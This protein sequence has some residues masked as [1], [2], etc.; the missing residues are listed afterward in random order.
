MIGIDVSA[1]QGNVDF[2]KVK[3][4]GYDFVIIRG[5][6][7]KSNVD[8]WFDRNIRKALANGLKVG[9]YWFIYAKDIDHVKHNARMCNAILN[10]YRDKLEMGVWAD[11]EYDSD[12]Y[13]PKLTK[14]E[15]TLFVKAFIEE[16]IKMGYDCGLY[17]NPDYINNK[18]NYKVENKPSLWKYPLWLAYYDVSEAKAKEYKPLIWQKTSK[19]KVNGVNGNV[20]IDVYFGTMNVEQPKPIANNDKYAVV[21][22]KKDNLNIRQGNGTKYDIISSFKKGTEVKIIKK[23]G[24]WWFVEGKDYKGNMVQGYCSKTY[25]KEI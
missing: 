11:W 20:D 17:A 25:L 21:E 23:V 5:G 9:V 24:N 8:K 18:F 3:E 12:N 10:N 19:G 16:M 22:T 2:K 6:F 4:S 15:R 13:R 1:Y 14:E 7:G